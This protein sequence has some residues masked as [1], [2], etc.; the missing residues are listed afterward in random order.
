MKVYGAGGEVNFIP[1]T[2]RFR[3]RLQSFASACVGL[4]RIIRARANFSRVAAQGKNDQSSRLRRRMS[5]GSANAKQ[6]CVKS[7]TSPN[8]RP[9][10]PPLPPIS[11]GLG[12]GAF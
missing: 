6:G 3:S 10:N 5:L 8:L 11:G 12:M 2:W 1:L 9:V 7:D 4:Q